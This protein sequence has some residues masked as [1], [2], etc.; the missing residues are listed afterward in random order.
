MTH[1]REIEN[2]CNTDCVPK[3]PSKAI[4]LPQITGRYSLGRTISGPQINA[5]KKPSSS[6][7]FIGCLVSK[8]PRTP[9]RRSSSA[10]SEM[11]VISRQAFNCQAMRDSTLTPFEMAQG[12]AHCLL[13]KDCCALPDQ[14]S[15]VLTFSWRGFVLAVRDR[16][17]AYP[18][19]IAFLIFS[20]TA[21]DFSDGILP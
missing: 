13:L 12:L 5:A 9:L 6:S 10:S 20:V 14:V 3:D 16:H 1:D 17:R 19:E 7:R 8:R 4:S 15:F 18:N 2:S 21:K 11:A